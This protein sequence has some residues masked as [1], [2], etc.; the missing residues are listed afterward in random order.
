MRMCVLLYKRNACAR[1]DE[2]SSLSM[3]NVE[4]EATFRQNK[5]KG[6]EQR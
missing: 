1:H 4:V 3:N 6:K 5:V 2:V